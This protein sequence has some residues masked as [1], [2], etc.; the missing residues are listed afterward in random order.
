M[1]YRNEDHSIKW[2]IELIKNKKINLRPPYQRNFIWTPKDQR[3]L[4][5]SIEIGFP[6]PSFFILE[7]ENGNYEMIDGQQ[8]AT[9]IYKYANNE[10][11]DSNKQSFDQIDRQKFLDYHLNI[12]L[13]ND[14][15]DGLTEQFFALVNKRGIHLN[16][17]EVN[18]AQYHDSDFMKLVDKIMD[19]QELIDLDIFTDK[20]KLRMNDR[21]TIEE[22]VAYLFSGEVYDKRS[23]VE[24]LFE[25]Q[26]LEQQQEEVYHRF[27]RISKKLLDLSK[28]IC[29]LNETRYK[30]KN[31]LFSLFCFVNSH[32]EE[33]FS[34]LKEQYKL[35]VFISQ[36]GYI[37]P[38]NDDCEPFKEYAINCVSQSN[39]KTARQDRLDFFD[40]L[41]CCTNED[42]NE[43]LVAIEDFFNKKYGVEIEYYQIGEYWLI[44]TSKFQ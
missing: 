38:S 30:Q 34:V 7:L 13:I 32:I 33:E 43:I 44:D 41:L 10:F 16:P 1:N 31:D 36:K 6:L 42:G 39:S 40:K 26:I 27:L 20:T 12:V 4:I 25:I 22:I 37:A 21:G 18:H 35:L 14:M 15:A 3:L 19:S 2:L 8:R 11:K 29:A 24:R 5:D 28:E 17:A 23:E 9:T